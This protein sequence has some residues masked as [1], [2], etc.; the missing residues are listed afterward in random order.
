MN[1]KLKGLAFRVMAALPFGHALYRLAQTFV[2]RNAFE[3][4]T[5]ALLRLHQ[6]HVSVYRRGD[7]GVVMEFGGGRDLLSALLLSQAG[8]LEVLVFDIDRHSNPAQV[9]HCISQLRS[10]QPGEWPPIADVDADLWRKYR[11][12]YIAPGDARETGLDP[13]S[14]SFVLST[15]TLEH[16]PEA[17]IRAINAECVR[18]A[19]PGALFSH[20]ID[21]KDHY[22]YSDPA[23]GMFN[24][25]RFTGREWRRWSPPN[26]NQN[27]LRH[28]DFT[29][30]FSEAGLRSIEV[31]A[32]PAPDGEL[33][34]VPLAEDFQR[35]DRQDLLIQSA[36]F[37][38][39]RT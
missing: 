38:L 29:S 30:L 22:Y 33:M 7:R 20:V 5:P 4:I 6:Y 35:Y 39:E 13:A 34:R 19:K 15:S 2:T 23:I 18:I 24:F 31:L 21:Y 9:N 8:A 10:L 36:Y 17:E 3:T 25:Y 16:I 27:R 28:S 26:N 37:V 14:V 32:N 12:R 1:W 11:I